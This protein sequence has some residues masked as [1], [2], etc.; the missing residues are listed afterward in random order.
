MTK[1]VL[2]SHFPYLKVKVRI[3]S[4]KN[5]E[6]AFEIESLVDTGFSGGLAVPKGIID[7]SITPYNDIAWQL[8]DET[9]VLTPAYS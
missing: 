4:G 1:P 5:I 3:G 8:A 7:S 6:Q 9:E 2:S